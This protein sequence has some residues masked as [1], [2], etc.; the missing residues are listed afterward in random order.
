MQKDC[1]SDDI[2]ITQEFQLENEVEPV[3]I[4]RDNLAPVDKTKLKMQFLK[5]PQAKP[6]SEQLDLT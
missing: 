2:Y 4:Q 1:K 6:Q 3:P 5:P